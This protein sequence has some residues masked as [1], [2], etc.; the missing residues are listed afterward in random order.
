MK[1][2]EW[3]GGGIAIAVAAQRQRSFIK[4]LCNSALCRARAAESS[5]VDAQAADTNP[6]ADIKY[7][8]RG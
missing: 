4:N 3:E 1:Y 6:D 5:Q 8:I 7:N 2:E